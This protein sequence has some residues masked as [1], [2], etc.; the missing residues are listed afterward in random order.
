MIKKAPLH[1]VA[2]AIV[3]WAIVTD[4]HF[5]EDGSVHT[6]LCDSLVRFS[7]ANPKSCAAI[8][9]DEAGHILS[10][11]GIHQLGI[12]KCINA[13]H[14]QG[15]EFT[16]HHA[17]A[18]AMYSGE[19]VFSPPSLVVEVNRII[20]DAATKLVTPHRH[21]KVARAVV[22]HVMVNKVKFD[23]D[24]EIYCDIIA[25]VS[26]VLGIDTTQGGELLAMTG[27]AIV[28][29]AKIRNYLD[30]LGLPYT[31]LRA[32]SD[33]V[34]KTHGTIDSTHRRDYSELYRLIAHI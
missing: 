22:N 5:D 20:A 28:G 9:M 6:V 16:Q 26:G 3:N 25:V 17:W 15:S 33:Y 34:A 10:T 19:T 23:Y 18:D 8:S 13:V 2:T 11:I 1:T 7:R 29:E 4:L 21:A 31:P 14:K 30:N 27:N 32:W 12:D 24:T